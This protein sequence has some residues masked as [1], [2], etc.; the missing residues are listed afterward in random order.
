MIHVTSVVGT[1]KEVQFPVKMKS[2]GISMLLGYSCEVTS[3][4]LKSVEK[5][6]KEKGVTKTECTHGTGNIE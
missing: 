5:S 6:F 3:T 1:S 4:L 2:M